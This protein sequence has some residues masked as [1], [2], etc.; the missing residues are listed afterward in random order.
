MKI[1]YT[2]EEVKHLFFTSDT[3]FGH[4]NIIKF[5]NRPY[6]NANEMNEALINNWNRVV[7]PDDTIF[8]LGDFAFGGSYLWNNMLDRLNGH[9]HLIIGNHDRKNLRQGY[10]TKFDSVNPQLQINIDGR[11]VYL[12]HYPFLCYGGSYRGDRDAVWQL[13]GHVHSGPLSSGKDSERLKMLF[14]Y[15]YDVGVDNNNFTPISWENIKIRIK[16]NIEFYDGRS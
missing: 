1:N 6:A 3:H 8:H 4:E 7:G 13:F 15:Q 9:I 14:P 11:L 2:G 10:V 5:C 12:N 16:N